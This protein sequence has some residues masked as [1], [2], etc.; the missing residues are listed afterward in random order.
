[1]LNS[2]STHYYLSNATSRRFLPQLE[3]SESY[4]KVWMI[5]QFSTIC[6]TFFEIFSQAN[7][8]ECTDHF[9]TNRSILRSKFAKIWAF[10]VEKVKKSNSKKQHLKLTLSLQKGHV[11]VRCPFCTN[12]KFGFYAL[13]SFKCNHP[14][15]SS[16]IRGFRILFWNLKFEWFWSFQLYD[17]VSQMVLQFGIQ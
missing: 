10:E 3:A 14:E 15:V 12:A 2:D 1:M 11:P 9:K 5:L 4:F 17:F 7:R 8:G 6:D 16:S 13:L